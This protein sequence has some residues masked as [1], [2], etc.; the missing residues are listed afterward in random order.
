MS[1]VWFVNMFANLQQ[2]Q[3]RP[4]KRCSDEHLYKLFFLELIST[5]KQIKCWAAMYAFM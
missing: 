2:N 1:A 3:S 4:K 5:I